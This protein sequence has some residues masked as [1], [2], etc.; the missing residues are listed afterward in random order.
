MIGGLKGHS[1]WQWMYIELL[2]IHKAY[3]G[4]GHARNLLQKAEDWAKA[5]KL[6]GLFLITEEWEGP[7]FYPKL[8]F[9]EYGRIKDFP[10]GYTRS[11]FRK[12]L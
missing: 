9:E 11:W 12:Y 6:T 2:W 8:G 7:H 5:E 4:Q 1:Q 3:R 10:P